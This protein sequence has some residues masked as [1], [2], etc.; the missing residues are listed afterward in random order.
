MIS[1]FEILEKAMRA[2]EY[3]LVNYGDNLGL[4]PKDGYEKEWLEAKEAIS[5][6]TDMEQEI[7]A[8]YWDPV[9][10]QRI[11]ARLYRG[12]VERY[13]SPTRGRK[14]F[15]IHVKP[16][17][18]LRN[19]ASIPSA[20][21]FTF[22]C[23]QKVQDEWFRSGKYETEAEERRKAGKKLEMNVWVQYGTVIVLEWP[24]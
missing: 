1:R 16:R 21:W 13:I 6:L 19:D 9:T 22:D 12:G 2:E 20:D 10:G 4:E 8:M 15:Y 17:A 5:V 3:R 7:A 18:K 11:N 24:D 14:V 23:T